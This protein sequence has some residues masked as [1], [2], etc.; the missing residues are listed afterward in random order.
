M[1][2]LAIETSS[3]RGSVALVE[4]TSVQDAQ[5]CGY[6]SHDEPNR[7]AE[8]LLSMTREV[9]QQASWDKRQIERVAVGLGPGSFTGV[10]IGIAQAQGMMLGLGASGVG[11]GSMSV[12]AAGL[13]FDDKRV[14]V[15]VRDARRDEFFVAAYT[16]TGRELLAP[17]TIAQEGARDRILEQF[18]GES[19]VIVGSI[20]SGFDCQVG[21]ETTEPDA[22]PLGRMALQA[23]P[24]VD[25]L[26]PQY[27]RGPNVVRPNLPPSPLVGPRINGG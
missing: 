22:R 27:V 12:I 6:T 10:R 8:R 19:F 26:V 2:V 11:I 15:V 25:L 14:R 18:G 1:R 13:P 17:H 4:G 21:P 9:L 24:Q 23:S 5:I 20:L 3:S 16:S 7:H